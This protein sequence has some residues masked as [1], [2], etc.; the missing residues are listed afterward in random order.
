MGQFLGMAVLLSG[1]VPLTFA[2]GSKSGMLDWLGRL[3]ATSAVVTIALTG[4]LQAVDGVALK[5]AA[6]A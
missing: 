4:V 6:D 1:L 2:L 5:A 3:A